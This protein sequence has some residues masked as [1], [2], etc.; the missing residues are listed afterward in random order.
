MKKKPFLVFPIVFSILSTVVLAANAFQRIFEPF[1]GWDIAGTYDKAYAFIDFILYIFF[2]LYI[3]RYAVGKKFEGP[4]AKSLSVILSIILSIGMS[5]FSVRF[6]FKLGDIGPLA[7]LI[8]FGFM[9][10]IVYNVIKE[11]GTGKAG[12]ASIAF[13]LIYATLKAVNL[14]Y[15]KY[16]EELP[17]IGPILSFA[18]I[19]AIIFAAKSVLGAFKGAKVSDAAKSIFDMQPKITKEKEGPG[20]ITKKLRKIK[21]KSASDL[22]KSQVKEQ[23]IDAYKHKVHEHLKNL[24]NIQKQILDNEA[25]G[26][27]DAVKQINDVKKAI[28]YMNGL[29]DDAQTLL[30]EITEL[31][32]QSAAGEFQGLKYKIDQSRQRYD[33]LIRNYNVLA[34][35]LNQLIA[36]LAEKYPDL[37]QSK[38]KGKEV[39]EKE[40]KDIVHEEEAIA[41]MIKEVEKQIE[42]QEKLLK[43]LKKNGTKIEE[44]KK[45]KI[46]LA[47]LKDEL[48]RLMEQLKSEEEQRKAVKKEIKTEKK[49]IKLAEKQIKQINRLQE[50]LVENNSLD[51]EIKKLESDMDNKAGIFE[52]INTK[53][54]RRK[55]FQ[56]KSKSLRDDIFKNNKEMK[57]LIYHIAEIQVN[58]RDLNTQLRK[59]LAGKLQSTEDPTEKK[60]HLEQHFTK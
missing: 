5:V 17:Y 46:E 32:K 28:A 1:F 2:F 30:N 16:L 35:K 25:F 12:A 53:D 37:L 26:E 34:P 23:E 22:R 19:F 56:R 54:K 41:D 21:E 24:K 3:S 11:F 31:E 38:K 20:W 59:Q 18:I 51:I 57:E 39:A 48:T 4:T 7:G 45:A 10:I 58:I 50:L 27:Q 15:I 9:A 40:K 47:Y 55:K 49:E 13:L 52:K 8:F 36:K 42:I 33:E 6:G 14:E 60:E 44:Q 29:N 43:E